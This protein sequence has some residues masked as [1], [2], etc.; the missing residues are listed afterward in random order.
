MQQ[1]WLLE[2]VRVCGGEGE[3]ERGK[4][5]GMERW[6]RGKERGRDRGKVVRVCVT[7]QVFTGVHNS[8]LFHCDMCAFHVCSCRDPEWVNPLHY[9]CSSHMT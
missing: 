8:D 1:K 5:G 6:E 9:T 4:E 2:V 3:R 7:S